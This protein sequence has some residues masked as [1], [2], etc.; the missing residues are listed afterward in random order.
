MPRLSLVPL[1]AL[2]LAACAQPPDAIAPVAMGDA[3]AGTPCREAAALLATERQTLATLS[4]A[5]SGAVAGD[6]IGVL[7]LGV[8]LSSVSGGDKAGLIGASKG[9]I[10]ALEARVASC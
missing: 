2:A 10:L 4:A 1:A 7:L 8:P 3:F 6:A 9:K 5:Q